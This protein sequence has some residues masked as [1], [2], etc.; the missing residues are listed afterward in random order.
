M[1]PDAWM[2][3]KLSTPSNCVSDHERREPQLGGRFLTEQSRRVG[4][5]PIPAVV[6]A[7]G[8]STLEGS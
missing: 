6:A 7:P 5:N 4:V 1:T 3:S 2:G 8:P